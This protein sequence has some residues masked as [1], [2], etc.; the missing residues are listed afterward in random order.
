LPI[1]LNAYHVFTPISSLLEPAGILSLAVSIVFLVAVLLAGKKSRSVFF[2][3]AVVFVPLLPSLYIPGTGENTFAERYLYLPSFGFVLLVALLVEWVVSHKT[4]WSVL[5]AG[6]LLFIM[7]L[8]AFATVQRI[9]VWRDDEHLWHDVVQH[10]PN[11]AV[12]HY[13]LACALNAQGRVDEAIREYQTAIRIQPAAVAYKSLGAAYQAKGLVA[14][15]V[16]QYAHAVQLQPGDADAHSLLAAASVESGALDSAIEHFR[17]AVQLQPDSA[18]A[19]YDLGRAYMESGRPAEA[20]PQLQ[21]AVQL[22]PADPLF[23][24][25]LNRALSVQ[26]PAARNDGRT[27]GRIER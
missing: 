11:S 18:D 2:A 25:T 26:A 24:S 8:S 10:S 7:G 13:N 3:L 20:I 15:A 6:V 27:G 1:H 14:E 12:P 22:N 17:M 9:A 21:T 5:L 16:E 4:R 19:R 23:R